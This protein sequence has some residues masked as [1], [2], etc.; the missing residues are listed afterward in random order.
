M[1]SNSLIKVVL[2]VLSSKANEDVIC[3][4]WHWSLKEYEHLHMQMNAVG[5]YRFRDG[6]NS[7]I[8]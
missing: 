1:D 5:R 8:P 6:H 3:K 7:F 4:V 2:K